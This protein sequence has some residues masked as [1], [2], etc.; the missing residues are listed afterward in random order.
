MPTKQS[1][2][3]TVESFTDDDI[4]AYDDGYWLGNKGHG[5]AGWAV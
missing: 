4:E 1:R 2:D 3:D 5:E